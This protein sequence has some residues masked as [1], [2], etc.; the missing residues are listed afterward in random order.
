MG[1]ADTSYMCTDPSFAKTHF[2]DLFHVDIL[3]HLGPRFVQGARGALLR[4]AAI[5]SPIA[6]R[7]RWHLLF[8][9]EKMAGNSHLYYEHGRLT[10]LVR[11][12]EY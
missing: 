12:Q 11:H 2:N 1:D 4:E 8:A 10:Q 6:R 9:E 7:P 5:V 3:T